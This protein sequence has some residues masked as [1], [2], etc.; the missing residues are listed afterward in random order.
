MV[1]RECEA[2][3]RSSWQALCGAFWA[4]RAEFISD[5]HC[6]CPAT[7][8]GHYKATSALESV[9]LASNSLTLACPVSCSLWNELGSG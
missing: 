7:S 4:C 9:S 2:M 3:S 8:V 1:Q 6:M 5:M